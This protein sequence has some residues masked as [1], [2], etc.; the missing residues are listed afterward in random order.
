MTV[1]LLGATQNILTKIG[2]YGDIATA[3]I[4]AR[5]TDQPELQVWAYIEE[6]SRPTGEWHRWANVV[7]EWIEDKDGPLD[8]V[9]SLFQW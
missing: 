8:S 5:V 6:S 3:S 4:V 7:E 1:S 2:D 9:H